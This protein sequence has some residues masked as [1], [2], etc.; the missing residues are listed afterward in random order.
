[1]PDAAYLSGAVRLQDEAGACPDP[2]RAESWLGQQSHRRGHHPTVHGLRTEGP[3]RPENGL[4]HD[5]VLDV[6]DIQTIRQMD[7]D[8]RV[9]DLFPGG[10]RALAAAV[11]VAFG[12]EL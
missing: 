1:M 3:V 12:L 10:E 11:A 4:E 5:S 7:L 6:A 9:G 8:R 2:G